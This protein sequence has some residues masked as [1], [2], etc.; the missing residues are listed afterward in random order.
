MVRAAVL[1]EFDVPLKI[2]ELETTPLGPRDVR[3]A[4]E[5]SGVCH[6]DVTVATGGSPLS[7]PLILGHEGA[8]SVLEVGNSVDRVRVGDRLIIGLRPVCGTCFFCIAGQPY[9]CL[10]QPEVV[11]KVRARDGDGAAVLSMAGIG[12]FAT[13]VIVDERMAV[14]VETELPAERLCLLGCGVTTG[15]GAALNTAQV[16]PGSTV[17]VIGC[18]GVG[19]GVIQGARIA[20]ASEI[21]AIDPVPLKREAAMSFGATG[22]IDPSAGDAVEQAREITRGVGFDYAFEVVGIPATMRQAWDVTR[23]GGTVVIVGMARTGTELTLTGT[24][25]MFEAKRFLGSYYGSTDIWRDLPRLVRLAETGRLDLASM[26]TRRLKLDEVND[27]F[28]AMQAGDVIR[29]VVIPS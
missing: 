21:V 24:E 6:S 22:G 9:L 1:H 20:G 11:Q 27:G 28:T 15:V 4:I 5:A 23:R 3:V 17:A 19:Q 29:S 25:V 12:S 2:E 13:E 18:G 10:L 16:V 7:L 8:G 26:V 14:R